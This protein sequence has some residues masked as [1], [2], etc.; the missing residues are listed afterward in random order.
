ETYV[1]TRSES[2]KNR[3]AGLGADWVG[4]YQDEIPGKFDAGILFP[5]AGNLVELALSQLD[6]GGKLIL[7]A[8]YM[9]P[10][11]V[12]DYKHIWMEHSIKSLAN[13]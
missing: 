11:E 6:S 5:P 7:G 12:K 1:I 2:N 4:G 10:I 9:T 13:I 3:A 8:V